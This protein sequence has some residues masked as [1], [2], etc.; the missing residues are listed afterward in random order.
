M[1]IESFAAQFGSSGAQGKYPVQSWNPPLSGDMDLVIKKDG[2]WWH[3]GV[4]FT[5]DSLVLLFSSILK[6]EGNE[7][8]LVSPVERWR[9]RVEDMPLH[10]IS[11]SRVGDGICVMTSERQVL[12]LDLD[13]LLQFSAIDGVSVPYIEVR[14]GLNARF[15][16]NAFYSLVE[17]ADEDNGEMVLDSCGHKQ[18]LLS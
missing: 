9:I 2:T 4:K 5:R 12:H 1:D 11:A 13:H 17:L 8:F 16:R 10:I 18:K 15:L 6:R 14:N 7:Y 3:E